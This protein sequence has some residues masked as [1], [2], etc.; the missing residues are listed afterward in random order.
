MRALIFLVDQV[1]D[2]RKKKKQVPVR[3]ACARYRKSDHAEPRRAEMPSKHHSRIRSTF[4]QWN[5]ALIKTGNP[6]MAS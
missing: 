2:Q 4:T 3:N 1:S 6:T 5:L